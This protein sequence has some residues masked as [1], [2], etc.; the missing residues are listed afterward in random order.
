MD[1]TTVPL[2]YRG[3]A[4]DTRMYKRRRRAILFG[5]LAI[6]SPFASVP[7]AIIFSALISRGSGWD[8]A[9]QRFAEFVISLGVLSIIG[10]VLS[11]SSIAV[12]VRSRQID[13][14][15]GAAPWILACFG[16]LINC[17]ILAWFLYVF[18]YGIGF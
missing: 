13:Q 5:A 11:V 8:V 18:K 16:L 9:L 7:Q 4:H 2:D 12:A 15:V 3:P 1:N 17:P 6:A 14:S 10:I